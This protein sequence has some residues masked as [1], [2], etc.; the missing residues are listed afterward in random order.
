MGALAGLALTVADG[1]RAQGI[2]VTVV[3]PKW[4]TPVNPAL[5]D[6]GRRHRLA[7][8]V[9]DNSRAGGVGS[10]TAQA[11]RDADVHTPLRE[12]GI[13]RR[14]LGHGSRAEVLAACGLTAQNITR[15]VVEL[16]T[17]LDAAPA[18]ASA[19]I[20]DLGT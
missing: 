10:A 13:P 14:F 2:G 6:L 3:D 4:V 18:S 1:V 5:A 9:E 15:V 11:L 12:F 7:I 20:D 8:T 16:L 19:G 17:G